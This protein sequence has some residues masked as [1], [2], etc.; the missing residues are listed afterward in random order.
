MNVAIIVAAGR[1]TRFG[2]EKPKQFLLL[3]GKP[4]VFH[5]LQ[6]FQDCAN[7][8]EIVAVLPSGE[9]AEFENLLKS[10]DLPKLKKIVAGG[11]T[12]FASVLNGLNSLQSENVEIVAVHD[13]ARPLVAI[14]EISATIEKARDTGAACLVTSVTDTIK[15]V[16]SDK[17]IKQTID[18]TKLRRAVTP[19]CFRAE[20]LRR[21]F[22]ENVDSTEQATD[23]C[24]L[25]E[26]LNLPIAT[27]EGSARNIKITVPEDLILAEALLQDSK[28]Q[29]PE[30]KV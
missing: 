7:V 13:G 9:I 11:A 22:A 23:E 24:Y 16:S 8:D 5:A 25:V 2:T 12:R 18:R 26:Q 17:L 4:V 3:R 14:A 27:V 1:G 29:S 30:S 21:A 20:I 28:V 10:F 6:Q 19:Q 15:E